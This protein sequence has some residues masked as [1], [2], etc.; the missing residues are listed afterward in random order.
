MLPPAPEPARRHPREGD[1]PQHHC[2]VAQWFEL[3]WGVE[4]W[5][6]SA[7]QLP[8]REHA[9]L[10]HLLRGVP[11]IASGVWMLKP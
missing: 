7:A 5:K 1:V 6:A 11:T 3:C 10:R 4:F 9:E 8:C 2:I